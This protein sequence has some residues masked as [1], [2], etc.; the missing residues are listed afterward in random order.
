MEI[1]IGVA[2]GVVTN[3]AAWWMLFRGYLPKA[4]FDTVICKVPRK[5]TIQ[6]DIP[7]GYFVRFKNIGQRSII[8]MEFQAKL[9]LKGFGSD[10]NKSRI[11]KL[12]TDGMNDYR[13]G[14]LLPFKK[15]GKRGAVY[16]DVNRVE[17]FRRL[18]SFPEKVMNKAKKY[19]LLLEDVLEINEGCGLQ[20]EAF[21]YD[22]FT[23]SRQLFQS[24]VYRLTDIVEKDESRQ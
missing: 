3:L 21:G 15:T 17:S 22:N 6:S 13:I 2:I 19:E 5:I 23:G 12:P 14:Q 7:V 4:K 16:I 9:I 1:I 8:D 18:D 20:I 10:E 11:V 24:K